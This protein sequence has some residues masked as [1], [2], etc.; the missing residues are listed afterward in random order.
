MGR[1]LIQRLGGDSLYPCAL[2][3][4]SRKRMGVEGRSPFPPSRWKTER[5]K[6]ET[7][8]PVFIVIL[9]CEKHVQPLI[10]VYL[11]VLCD[12][13]LR[14]L[15][16]SIV[17]RILL[18]FCVASGRLGTDCI[19]EGNVNVCSSICSSRFLLTDKS[20]FWKVFPWCQS[21]PTRQRIHHSKDFLLGR[22]QWRR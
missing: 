3:R 4:I 15:L 8:D 21:S 7:T 12:I 10:C 6:E 9:G 20:L 14:A 11:A 16:S 2:T 18:A 13:M 22:S 5:L 19:Y 17:N 1:K